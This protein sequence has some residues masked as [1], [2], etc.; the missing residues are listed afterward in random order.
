MSQ[1]GI[2]KIPLFMEDGQRAN[3]VCRESE[4]SREEMSCGLDVEPE[5][6]FREGQ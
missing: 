5:I 2:D 4:H 3:L 1:Q 6:A